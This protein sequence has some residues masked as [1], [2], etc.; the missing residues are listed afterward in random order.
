MDYLP[1]IIV[2]IRQHYITLATIED[3]VTTLFRQ[4]YVNTT[5]IYYLRDF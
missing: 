4:L 5:Q 1:I 3:L 2:T